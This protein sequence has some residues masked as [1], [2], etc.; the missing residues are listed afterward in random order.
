MVELEI[1][2]A[3]LR[4]PDKMMALALELDAIM[5]LSYKVDTNHDIVYLEFAS[6][7]PSLAELSSMFRKAGL[8]A[9]FVGAMPPELD[10]KK[11]TQRIDL[12]QMTT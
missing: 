7:P 12:S 1:Y 4:A 6:N 11:K 5:G 8:E 2:A 10:N 9:R 3:G